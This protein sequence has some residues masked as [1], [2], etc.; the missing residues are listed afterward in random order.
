MFKTYNKRR[1]NFKKG[2]F[3]SE[4]ERQVSVALREQGHDLSYEKDRFDYFL[5]R[6]YTPDFR[7]KGEKFDFFIEV[8]G[9][10]PPDQRSKLLAVMVRHPMLPLFV[11]LQKPH[12]KLNKNS[13]TSVCQW[14]EK[15]GIA[16]CP[17]PIPS[18]FLK[19][20]VTGQK[21]SFRAPSAKAATRARS[22]K[23]DGSHASAVDTDT[24]PTKT[25]QC[26]LFPNS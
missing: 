5:K 3:R 19:S 10:F 25:I 26:H 6:F 14:C 11:A 4:L 7:V 8:K 2:E 20:W 24:T 9:W 16:W 18:D 12:A 15:H 13:K 1:E 22:T 23:P 17:T 21:L